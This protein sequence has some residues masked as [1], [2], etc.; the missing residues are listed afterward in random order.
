MWYTGMM[1]AHVLYVYDVRAVIVCAMCYMNVMY[2]MCLRYMCCV[3]GL[4]VRCV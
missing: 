2:A 3:R 1:Y 4:H